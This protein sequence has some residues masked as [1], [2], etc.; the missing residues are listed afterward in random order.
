MPAD[1]APEPVP[2]LPDTGVSFGP[3]RIGRDG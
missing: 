2:L 3:P 1:S